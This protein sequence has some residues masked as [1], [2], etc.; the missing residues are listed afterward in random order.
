MKNYRLPSWLLGLVAFL[1]LGV[2]AQAMSPKEIQESLVGKPL[3]GKAGNDK[4]FTMT[5]QPDGVVSISGAAANDTGIWRLSDAGYCT[6]WKTIRAGQ[7]RC[8]TVQRQ[9][10]GELIVYNL[11]GSISGRIDKLR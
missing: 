9:E 3:A 1:P 7:E 5:L 2:Q 8:F 4:A 11:D 6:T 10:G